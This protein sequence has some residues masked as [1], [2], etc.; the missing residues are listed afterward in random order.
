MDTPATPL[1]IRGDA[2]TL[3]FADASVDLIVT[4]P[5]YSD[6]DPVEFLGAGE[7]GSDPAEQAKAAQRERPRGETPGQ[8]PLFPE[9]S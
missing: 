5:P 9:A 8:I 7:A 2:R 3:P 4:S 1:L 6:A